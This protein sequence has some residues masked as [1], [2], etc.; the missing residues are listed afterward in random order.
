MRT[1]HP[2][3][4]SHLEGRTPARF[5]LALGILL[6]LGACAPERAPE[7]PPEAGT[8][9]GE[10]APAPTLTP[11]TLPP[12]GASP[13]SPVVLPVKVIPAT[14]TRVVD[15]DT[16]HVTLADGRGERV[17]FIGMDAPESTT[18][19]ETLG[20]EATLYTRERIKGREV[21]LEADVEERDRYGRFLAYVWL[22]MPT[23]ADEADVR[24][25]MLNGRM[26]V[27]GFAQL[28]TVPPNVRYAGAFS[29]FQE[30]ARTAGRGLWSAAASR[31]ATSF[32]QAPGSNC[33]PSY[34]GVCIPPAPPDLDCGDVPQR[35][36]EVRPPD[37]H[38]FDPDG[39][40][41]GCESG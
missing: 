21:F 30:E 12:P 36:F 9:S 6:L 15:G 33:D 8:A 1:V 38:G 27:D 29:R 16:A 18:R 17:R 11:P 14:V 2:R 3:P 13:S 5:A 23:R 26:I 37:P 19:L 35:R 20:R 24:Q 39:D 4:G 28:M 40:G 25:H 41:V 31:P 34:P 32:A 22:V 10:P 7:V